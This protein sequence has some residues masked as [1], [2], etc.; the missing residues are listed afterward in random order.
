MDLSWLSARLERSRSAATRHL[1]KRTDAMM[2]LVDA[3]VQAVRRT[4]TDL[5]PVVLD[6]LGLQAAVEW[7]AREFEART[8]IRCEV[9]VGP[10]VACPDRDV[11]TAL[12]RITQEALTNV[13]RHAGATRVR[14]TLGS[15]DDAL[16]LAV[17]DDGRGITEAEH[18]GSRSLGLLGMRER[19]R[20]FGGRID[21]A[22]SPGGGTTITATIPMAAAS[23]ATAATESAPW[24][25]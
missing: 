6:D 20:L 10:V 24:P 17:A 22:G 19:A 23:L 9:G 5:R 4:A 16:R 1:H 13:A 21:V 7:Q 25:G 8:G 18:S 2:H 3:T 12:F 11:A 14:V 15:D